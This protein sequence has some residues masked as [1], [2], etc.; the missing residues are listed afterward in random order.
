MRILVLCLGALMGLA[1]CGDVPKQDPIVSA[2]NGDSVNIIQPLFASYSD[3]ELL[4]KA[5][6][7]CQRGSKKFAERVSS[8]NLPEYQGTEYLFLCLTK[9]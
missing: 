4:A 8:R 2:Y 1:A 7:I 9:R 5:D 3:E 6:S